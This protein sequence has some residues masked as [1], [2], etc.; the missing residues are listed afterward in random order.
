MWFDVTTYILTYQFDG[1]QT[2]L[3]NYGCSGSHEIP[4]VLWKPKVYNMFRRAHHSATVGLPSQYLNTFSFD[5]H[6]NV[7]LTWRNL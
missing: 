3:K 6:F 2:F 1:A 4:R 5:I 7:I